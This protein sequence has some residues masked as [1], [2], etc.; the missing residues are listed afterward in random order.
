MKKALLVLSSA[1]LMMGSMTACTPILVSGLAWIGGNSIATITDRRSTGA[2][3]N[4]KILEK[5]VF[6]EI[7]NA[8]DKKYGDK[9][10]SHVTVTA[11]NGR[12]LISGEVSD[13]SAKKVAKEVAL[14]SLDVAEVVEEL[15]VGPTSTVAQRLIDTKTATA[16][17]TRLLGNA[18]GHLNQMKVTV[19]RNIVY[20]MGILTA[21]ENKVACAIAAKTSGVQRVISIV[22]VMTPEQIK[23]R[24]KLIEPKNTEK[25]TE[26]NEESKE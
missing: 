12:V 17:R 21:Y 3:V 18:E 16:V 1:A 13:E 15:S 22:E 10:E 23:Q 2:V 8:F 7:K 9:L 11:Y 19:E 5:R 24:E 25:K 26:A 4:D 20:L 6:L 14:K